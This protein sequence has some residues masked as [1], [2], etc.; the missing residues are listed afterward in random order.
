MIYFCWKIPGLSGEW[1]RTSLD[2][3][4]V[5]VELDALLAANIEW[6]WLLLEEALSDKCFLP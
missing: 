4:F 1:Q 3:D 6:E 5:D 2:T